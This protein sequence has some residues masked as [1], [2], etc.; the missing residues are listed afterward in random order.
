MCHPNRLQCVKQ[1]AKFDGKCR[2]NC[3]G[4]YV[5][6]YSKS[7][8]NEDSFSDFWSKVEDDYMKFKSR[9]SVNFPDELKGVF[10]ASVLEALNFL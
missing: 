4:L 3:E 1:V 8:L 7:K 6:S 10:E 9:M 2:K 5:T